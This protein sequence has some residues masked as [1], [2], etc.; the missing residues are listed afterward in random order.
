[1]NYKPSTIFALLTNQYDVPTLDNNN[2]KIAVI[3]SKDDHRISSANPA[4]AA[5]VGGRV[6]GLC[7]C[8]A[9]DKGDAPSA[10]PSNASGPPSLAVVLA[11]QKDAL[12]LP[13]HWQAGI[14][15]VTKLGRDL[16]KEGRKMKEGSHVRAEDNPADLG[17]G[18]LTRISKADSR[19]KWQKGRI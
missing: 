12:T 7:Y 8:L 10:Q 11:I 19:S 2:P 3:E 17:T 6:L 18:G 13:P 1:M 4:E 16:A 15:E 9:E 5:P 14:S